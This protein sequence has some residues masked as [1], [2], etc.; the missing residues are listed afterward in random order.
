MRELGDVTCELLDGRN[1]GHLAVLTDR[2]P[3]V[4]VVWVD[5]DGD[6]ILVNTAE[7]RVKPDAVRKDPRI[8]LSI[9]DQ[10]NPYKAVAIR[11]RVVDIRHEGAREHIDKLA[12]KY[13]DEDTYPGPPDETRVLLVIEA[14]HVV[15]RVARGEE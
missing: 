15:E 10:E 4:S 13:L 9:H 8:G 2:G 12:Q 6:R 11:G 7:G 3:H 5:R 1:F 14:E